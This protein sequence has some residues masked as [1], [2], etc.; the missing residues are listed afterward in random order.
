MTALAE[1]EQKTLL[2]LARLAIRNR[3]NGAPHPPDISQFDITE[4][5]QSE[6][7]CFVTL[8][9]SDKLRGCI[10]TTTPIGRLHQTVMD[11]AVKSAF[12][13]QRFS[14]LKTA[15]FEQCDI[16][17]SV[18]SEANEIY[19]IYKI[20]LGKHGVII[21][22]NSRRAVFLPQV[23]TQFKWNHT[24]LLSQ[25]SLKAGLPEDAWQQADGLYTFTTQNFGEKE[26]AKAAN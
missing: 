12:E 20:E 2:M 4:T 15:E 19:S 18:L 25:L 7:A 3:M 22:H 26:L 11:I 5:M 9:L 23:A 8:H 13:D 21:E 6:L 14:P 24:E 17:I 16:D 10:G 1:P